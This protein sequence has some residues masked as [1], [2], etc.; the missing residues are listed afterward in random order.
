MAAHLQTWDILE[1]GNPLPVSDAL[2]FSRSNRSSC[3]LW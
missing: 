2:H 3:V 1:T